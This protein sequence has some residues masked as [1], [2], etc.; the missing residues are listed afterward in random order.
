MAIS[1][2]CAVPAG[3]KTLAMI[4]AERGVP[5]HKVQYIARSQRI[6]PIARAGVVG[7]FDPQAVARIKAALRRTAL[8]NRLATAEVEEDLDLGEATS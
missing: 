5:L 2:V 7:L 6:R 4:A 8:R 1:A 3:A